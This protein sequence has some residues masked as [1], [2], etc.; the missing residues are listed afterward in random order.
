MKKIKQ[1]RPIELD[2]Y[3]KPSEREKN[4]ILCLMQ[5]ELKKNRKQMRMLSSILACSSVVVTTTTLLKL[6][7][8]IYDV[9]GTLF[10]IAVAVLLWICFIANIKSITTNKILEKNIKN[11]QFE[12]LDCIPF[13]HYYNQ[14][15]G[16]T[17]GSVKVQTKTGVPCMVNYVVD[18]ETALLCE[19]NKGIKI[20]MLLMFDRETKESRVFTERMLSKG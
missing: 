3:R 5:P 6:I 17:E 10:S 2:G 11:G 7:E 9:K 19:K 15:E 4:K 13:W 14:D 20:P 12:V 8:G 1:V 18:I 16:R